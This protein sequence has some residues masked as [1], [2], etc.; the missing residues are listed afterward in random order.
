MF[1]D[2]HFEAHDEVKKR[3]NARTRQHHTLDNE[4]ETKFHILRPI[5]GRDFDNIDKTSQIIDKNRPPNPPLLC[6][7][8]NKNEAGTYALFVQITVRAKAQTGH[9]F[10][11]IFA[12][13]MGR[14]YSLLITKAQL[15]HTRFCANRGKSRS[16]R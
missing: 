11:T 6:S 15:E 16:T 14:S 1:R 8:D 10:S 7:F 12:L 2:V 9:N 13:R 5:K 4:A 3:E